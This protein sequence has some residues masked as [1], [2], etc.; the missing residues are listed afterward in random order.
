M[1]Y[2]LYQIPALLCHQGQL[3]GT[4]LP[5]WTPYFRFCWFTWIAVPLRS[6]V[7]YG[8]PNS[9]FHTL[10]FYTIYL[11]GCAIKVSLLVR[12][13]QLEFPSSASL[14]FTC[15]AVPSR[16]ADWYGSPNLNLNSLLPCNT[17]YTIYLH[18]CAIKVSWLVRFSH[19]EL[20]PSVSV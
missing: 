7:W 20:P 2:C 11:H 16:S 6:A 14:S 3:I 8:F 9:Y 10:L 1:Q 5:I 4:V 17:V 19:F 12:F 13:S 15:I 18:C